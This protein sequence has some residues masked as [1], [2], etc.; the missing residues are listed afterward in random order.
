LLH[1]W[2][3][4]VGRPSID[5]L[6]VYYRF[7]SYVW[8]CVTLIAFWAYVRA[9]FGAVVAI[10]AAALLALS[11]PHVLYAVEAALL[12][13]ADAAERAQPGGLHQAHAPAGWPG[14]GWRTAW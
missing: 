2:T 4:L 13:L 7:P 9:S 6:E 12:L 8:S 3:W 11:I 14:R 5:Q 1:F 10:V